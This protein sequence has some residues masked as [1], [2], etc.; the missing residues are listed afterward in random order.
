MTEHMPLKCVKREQIYIRLDDKD[1]I[2]D[3][4]IL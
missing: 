1:K 2:F 3:G 4:V